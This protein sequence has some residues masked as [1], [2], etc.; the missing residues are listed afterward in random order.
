MSRRTPPL[1][2][3]SA[4]STPMRVLGID[5]G[6]NRTGYAVIER[7][8]RGPAIREGGILGSTTSAPLA[9]RLRELADGLREVLDEFTPEAVA[10]EQVFS[11]GRFPKSALLM[12]HARGAMLLTVAE[13]GIPVAHYTPTQIKRM[14]TG[15]G[16]ANKEQMQSA[17][18]R[19]LGLEKT[20]EPHDVADAVAA[21]LCHLHSVRFAA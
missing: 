18:R 19:E 5:P 9:V 1:T 20:P 14:L 8:R 4:A 11:T 15:S 12:A 21:A 17:V 13:R 2:T 3:V 16:R 7:G 6:L 10:L